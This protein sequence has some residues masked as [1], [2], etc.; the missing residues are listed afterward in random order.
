MFSHTS[1]LYDI[2]GQTQIQVTSPPSSCF[3]FS[4]K[5]IREAIWVMNNNKA[6]DEEGFQ[7]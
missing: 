7:A 4:N 3:L 1:T 6:A 5:D 2:L